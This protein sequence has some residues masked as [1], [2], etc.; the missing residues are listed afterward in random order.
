MFSFEEIQKIKED[1]KNGIP[2][3]ELQ[4]KYSVSPSF[5]SSLNHGTYFYD[6]TETYPLYQYC[7][8]D[9]DYDELIELLVSSNLILVE[10]ARQLDIGYSTVKKI[11]SGKLRKGLYPTYP[12]RK[13]SPNTVKANQVKDLLLNSSLTKKEI[14]SAVSV[15]EETIRKINLGQTYHDDKLIY[16]LRNL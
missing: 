5:F 15:S 13:C 6:E 9:K 12:I 3:L 14:M 4:Q 1:I 16:P 10:I 8:S 7:K 2:Y 11:N